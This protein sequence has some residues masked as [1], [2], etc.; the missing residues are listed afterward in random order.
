M[1]LT[2]S[3]KFKELS[4]SR[5]HFVP[6]STRTRVA[7]TESARLEFPDK[8]AAG[9]WIVNAGSVLAYFDMGDSTVTATT[10]SIP[11]EAG[12]RLLVERSIAQ[13]HIAFITASGVSTIHTSLAYAGRGGNLSLLTYTPV[14]DLIMAQ[15]PSFYADGESVLI[16]SARRIATLYDIS[17]NNR[18]FTQ[19]TD[20]YKPLLSRADNLENYAIS[21]EDISPADYIVSR[22]VKV[23]ATEWK[24]DATASATHQLYQVLPS[25]Y[26]TAFSVKVKRGTGTRDARFYLLGPTNFSVAI[27]L[28]TGA[29]TP[30]ANTSATVSGP[31]GEGYYKIDAQWSGVAAPALSTSFFMRIAEAGGN[32]TYSGDNTSSI[33]T[34]EFHIRRATSDPTYIETTTHR[35]HAGINGHRTLV[36]DG[37]DDFLQGNT[38]D[39]YFGASAKTLFTVFRL[40]VPVRTVNQAIFGNNNCCQFLT[41]VTTEGQHKA[42]NYDGTS[43][44]TPVVTLTANEIYIAAIT[45]DGTTLRSS[46]NGSSVEVASGAST[47][48]AGYTALLGALA[49][50]KTMMDLAAVIA[51]PKVL[52]ADQIYA[53]SL[54]LQRKFGV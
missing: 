40:P 32:E 23:S 34:K 7:N 49:T 19:A 36:F 50:E 9:V 27:N 18:H 54:G 39:N 4:A 8:P 25:M 17:G 22:S 38:L 35:W 16:D 13:T 28:A 43:D 26:V 52:T 31:D 37:V 30:G 15:S 29:L 51:F 46:L 53:I 45:H 10:A 3:L 21:S 41:Y 1:V 6:G 5:A 44:N 14:E 47:N 12:K 42:F 33:H 2:P 24:E 48:L 20:G 11:I